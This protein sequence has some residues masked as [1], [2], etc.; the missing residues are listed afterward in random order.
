M[1]MAHAAHQ[2]A[3]VPLPLRGAPAPIPPPFPE[4]HGVEDMDA[5]DLPDMEGGD[6]QDPEDDALAEARA[7]ARRMLRLPEW[8]QW[9]EDT[10]AWCEVNHL[11]EVE[12]LFPEVVDY[13]SPETYRFLRLFHQ[14]PGAAFAS[15]LLKAN[16]DAPLDL[17]QVA[18]LVHMCGSFAHLLVAYDRHMP[19]I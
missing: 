9:A 7:Y 15:A 4:D 3:A 11:E 19:G 13:P 16:Q 5:D 1:G 18:H 12:K 2:M 17:S 10:L 14:H 6:G 8:D